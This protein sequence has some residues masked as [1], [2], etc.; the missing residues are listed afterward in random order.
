MLPRLGL[1]GPGLRLGAGT[2]G[3][4]RTWRAGLPPV[5]GHVGWEKRGVDGQAPTSGPE[6]MAEGIIKIQLCSHQ[7]L[8]LKEEEAA[9]GAE[10]GYGVGEGAYPS[11]AGSLS[12]TLEQIFLPGP[13]HKEQLRQGEAAC[14]S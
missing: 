11:N 1:G 2:R 4:G 5:L 8:G 10:W 3:K 13:G 12:F 7:R 6:Q 14:G 9:G